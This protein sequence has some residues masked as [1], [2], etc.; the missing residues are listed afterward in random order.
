VCESLSLLYSQGN[1]TRDPL[2]AFCFDVRKSSEV[3]IKVNG[4]LGE[5][6]ENSLILTGGVCVCAQ[7]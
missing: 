4:D 1:S 6:F 3:K 2:A 7:Q 5:A